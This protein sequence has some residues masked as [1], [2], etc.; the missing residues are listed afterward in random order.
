MGIERKSVRDV[1]DVVMHRGQVPQRDARHHPGEA[2]LMGGGVTLSPCEKVKRARSSPG[3]QTARSPSRGTDVT[4]K[5]AGGHTRAGAKANM[6]SSHQRGS[7][8]IRRD[9]QGDLE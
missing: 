8:E 4:N 1:A 3:T 6:R 2:E 5:R 9:A 7:T